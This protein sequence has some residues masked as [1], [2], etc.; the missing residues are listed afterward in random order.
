MDPKNAITSFLHD[1]TGGN[2]GGRHKLSLEKKTFLPGD[3][4]KALRDQWNAAGRDNA[5]VLLRLTEA[6]GSNPH[7]VTGW[8]G[9]DTFV[10]F[11]ES[12][13]SNVSYRKLQG[14][15]ADETWDTKTRLV[16]VRAPVLRKN[17]EQT[18]VDALISKARGNTKVESDSGLKDKN[19]AKKAAL[20]PD[21]KMDMVPAPKHSVGAPEDAPGRNKYEWKNIDE[22]GKVKRR[23]LKH[24]MMKGHDQATKPGAHGETN[25]NVTTRA[26]DTDPQ[27]DKRQQ[28]DTRTEG[29]K[30]KGNANK[31]GNTTEPQMD[32]RQQIDVRNESCTGGCGY[33]GPMRSYSGDTVKCPECGARQLVD[34][35]TEGKEKAGKDFEHPG[36]AC[37]TFH[38][39]KTHKV[40]LD[41]RWN[42]NSRGSKEE[43]P[44]GEGAAYEHPGADCKTFHPGK[45]HKIWL[46]RRWNLNSRGSRADTPLGE[47]KIDGK[48][49]QLFGGKKAAPLGAK[50][51]LLMMMLIKK[52]K[53]KGGS[54]GKKAISEAIVDPRRHNIKCLGCGSRHGNALGPM[55]HV[56]ACPTCE[57]SRRASGG[58]LQMSVKKI[59]S[60]QRSNLNMIQEEAPE[61]DDWVSKHA[62]KFRAN[63]EKMR[64]GHPSFRRRKKDTKGT[65]VS[66]MPDKSGPPEDQGSTQRV[67]KSYS[68]PSN[69]LDRP[70]NDKEHPPRHVDPAG[71]SLTDAPPKLHHRVQ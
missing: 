25:Q 16:H 52:G 45:T 5:S 44:L 9:K 58:G 38:P 1:A 47:S 62:H 10:C 54:K 63:I 3:T 17:M 12:G 27:I 29:G 23:G 64:S 4:A 65:S 56:K 28:I 40:W 49:K 48:S 37:Q 21:G 8:D 60:L 50:K 43:T 31:N 7:Y 15:K 20:G 68:H 19:H 57:A 18:T 2:A 61:H 35:R 33:T 22:S 69:A 30:N 53:D 51:P 41:R 67:L 6:D 13:L 55:V 32:K 36:A 14:M 39:G 34:V 46:D 66:V 11:T 26:E 59:E 24:A 70:H 42:L 71:Q